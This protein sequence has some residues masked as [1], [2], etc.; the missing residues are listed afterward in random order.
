MN[1]L[2]LTRTGFFTCISKRVKVSLKVS[3]H[4]EAN[5]VQEPTT[6]ESVIRLGRRDVTVAP[7][8]AAAGHSAGGGID[9]DR[10]HAADRHGPEQS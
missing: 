2:R 10:L 7:R 4:C 1:E 9:D 8:I 6:V 3:E 5:S